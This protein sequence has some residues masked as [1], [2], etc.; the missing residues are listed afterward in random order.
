MAGEKGYIVLIHVGRDIVEL[1]GQDFDHLVP[2]GT[3]A[4]LSQFF[5]INICCTKFLI[6]K[7][8]KDQ[9]SD[10]CDGES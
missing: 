6:F 1:N 5:Q 7:S 4:S 2:L 3:H 9:I 10:P 8:K